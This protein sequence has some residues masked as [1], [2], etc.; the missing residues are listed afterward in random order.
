MLSVGLHPPLQ[1]LCFRLRGSCH[2]LRAQHCLL[3]CWVEL[4]GCGQGGQL[5]PIFGT[6]TL[7]PR[8]L[9][10]QLLAQYCPGMRATQPRVAPM[11]CCSPRVGV[12][13]EALQSQQEDVTPWIQ[14]LG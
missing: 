5:F 11:S 13:G 2:L 1:S 7:Q 9:A 6:I 12:T 14:C 10:E 8:R 3:L 4:G